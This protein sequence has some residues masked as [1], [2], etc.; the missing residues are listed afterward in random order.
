MFMTTFRYWLTPMELF[1]WIESVWCGSGFATV[2]MT[3][4]LHIRILLILKVWTTEYFTDFCSDIALVERLLL[5]L[6]S[7]VYPFPVFKK[8]SAVLQG[9][10]KVSSR[11]RCFRFELFF[12]CDNLSLAPYEFDI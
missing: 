1:G 4:L 3:S 2:T 11:K 5:F 6:Q 12:R 7:C 8:Y 9:V 10:L